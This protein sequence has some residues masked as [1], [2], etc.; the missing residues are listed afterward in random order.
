MR[1]FEREK[2]LTVRGII[3]RH[4]ILVISLCSSV[5]AVVSAVDAVVVAQD[6]KE[7]TGKLWC[8][9]VVSESDMSHDVWSVMAHD[10]DSDHAAERFIIT[11]HKVTRSNY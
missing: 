1:Y 9:D 3:G 4:N 10:P 8:D 11:I 2:Y 5:T 7:W 6:D